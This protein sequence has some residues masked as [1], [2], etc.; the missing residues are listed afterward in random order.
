M[1][2]VVARLVARFFDLHRAAAE[3]VTSVHKRRNVRHV[4]EPEQ[5]ASRTERREDAPNLRRGYLFWGPIVAAILATESLAAAAGWLHKHLGFKIVHWPTISSTIG[6]LEDLWSPTA[7][8]VVGLLAAGAFQALAIPEKHE[9]RTPQG[10]VLPPWQRSAEPIS[11]PWQLS[12][13][14][15]VVAGAVTRIFTDDKYV[16]GYAIYGSLAIYGMLVPSLLVLFFRKDVQ[17]P[18]LFVTF[19]HLRSRLPWVATI[20]AAGLA[21]L[22][23]HLALYPWPD[24]TREPSQYAGLTS[25]KARKKAQREIKALRA[26][27]PQ[28]LSYST[29]T[30]GISGGHDAWLVFFTPAKGSKRAPMVCVVVVTEKEVTPT[31]ECST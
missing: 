9:R 5:V 16:L 28:Q 6:H 19:R 29:Q 23:I 22:V 3:R 21:I 8:I 7:A 13:L 30:R 17:F 12:V 20:V 2:E 18:T 1:H 4:T 10:R 31:P 14:L 11:Y 15:A 24:I 26:G 27:K 25:T